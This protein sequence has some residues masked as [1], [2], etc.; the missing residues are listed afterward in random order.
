VW[1]ASEAVITIFFR[2]FK[3]K[4]YESLTE[5][6]LNCYEFVGRKISL[7]IRFLYPY[8]E[9]LPANLGTVCNEHGEGVYQGKYMMEKQ[10]EGR[11]RH[12]MLPDDCWALMFHMRS[13]GIN[14]QQPHFSGTK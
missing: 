12:S 3:A 7:Q 10:Y 6:L 13:T 14:Y 8:P 4:N 11:W 1:R 2:Y 9:F 5:E